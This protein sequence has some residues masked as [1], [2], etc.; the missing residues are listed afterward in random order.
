MAC[1]E[2]PRKNEGAAPSATSFERDADTAAGMAALSERL[3][4][5]SPDQGTVEEF[6][7]L[8]MMNINVV[9]QLSRFTTHSRALAEAEVVRQ[10]SHSRERSQDSEPSF[11]DDRISTHYEGFI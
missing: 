6:P 1:T 7:I 9:R 5:V 10:R 2:Y 4:E 11:D 8:S 3:R